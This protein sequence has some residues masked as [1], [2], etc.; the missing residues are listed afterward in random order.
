MEGGKEARARGLR[1]KKPHFSQRTREM[2]HPLRRLS[3][4]TICGLS[5]H[6]TIGG[7]KKLTLSDYQALAEFRF[8]IRRFLRFSEQAVRAAGVGPGQY[9]LMLV[10]KVISEGVG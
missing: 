9:L 10:I 1:R 4:Y 8:Q 7:M 2:G 6:D 5:R 3:Y